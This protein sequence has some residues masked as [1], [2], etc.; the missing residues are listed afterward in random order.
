MAK[1]RTITQNILLLLSTLIVS[2][3]VLEIFSGQYIKA[4]KIVEKLNA[5]ERKIQNSYYP[6]IGCYD[7]D[8]GWGF[9]PSSQGKQVTPDFEVEYSMNSKGMRDEEIPA[10]KPIGK[11]RI[12]VLG[13]SLV[14]GEGVNYGRRFTEIIEDSLDNTDV[15]NMGVQGYGMDQS[16]LQLERDG[17]QFHPD[18]VALFAINPVFDRCR[19]FSRLGVLKPRFVLNSEKDGIVLQDLK[20]VRDNFKIPPL[21][22]P[23]LVAE[24][25]IKAKGLPFAGSKLIALLNYNNKIRGIDQKIRE[26]DARTWRQVEDALR[27]EKQ[28]VGI[29]EEKDFRRLA[30][31]ILQKYSTT[32][33]EHK[34]DFIV[35]HIDTKEE[36]FLETACQELGIT[37]LELSWVLSRASKI[38]SLVFQIDQHYNDFAH[39]VIGEYAG[40]FM[41][42]KYILEK[43]KDYVYEFLGKF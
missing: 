31:F 28:Q 7:K 10:E 30:Y 17:L 20:F 22:L 12:L 3:V 38:K 21:K 25:T 29:Y 23:Q 15:I 9:I 4:N 2:L 1:L 35:V 27:K 40:D 16:L 24:E 33:K 11:F 43:S 37:Y 14:F 18:V 41:K 19:Y 32:C 39:K 34:A 5:V 13:D 6:R 36:P 42:K 26:L 8:L